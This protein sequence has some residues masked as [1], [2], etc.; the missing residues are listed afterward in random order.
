MDD[1]EIRNTR[2]DDGARLWR[3]VRSIAA[4]D[5]NSCYA[6]LLWCTYFSQSTL[7]AE[8]QQEGVEEAVL[9]GFVT[10]FTPPEK[11][12]TVFVWQIAVDASEQGAG[13]GLTLLKELVQ[14]RI[15]ADPSI[16]ALEATISPTNTASRRLFERL[17]EHFSADYSYSTLFP[18]SLFPEGAHEEEE[19][20]RIEPLQIH[21]D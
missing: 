1:F 17:A 2:K 6:Y 16:R 4:L 18:P 14:R 19:L 3:L 13:I 11:P 9:A 8:R 10:A 21:R 15:S 12:D 7:V 5:T 20:I